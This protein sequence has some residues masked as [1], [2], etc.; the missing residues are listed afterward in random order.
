MRT[1]HYRWLAVL[2]TAGIVVAMSIPT[3]NLGNIQPAL[4]FDKLIH[5]LLFGGFGGLWLRGLCPP[6][7]GTRTTCFYRRGGL[8]FV[9]GVLFAGGTEVYQYVLPVERVADPYDMLADLT[10][11]ALAFIGYYAFYVWRPLQTSGKGE[12]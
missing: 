11:F 9:G 12:G 2:W 10:G 5:A 8:F 6:A 4:G 3:G 1:V 7:N